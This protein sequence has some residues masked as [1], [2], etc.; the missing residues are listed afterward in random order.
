MAKGKA[1]RELFSVVEVKETM[2][3]RERRPICGRLRMIDRPLSLHAGGVYRADDK[4]KAKYEANRRDLA[5]KA[6]RLMSLVER[7]K[8]KN[9]PAQDRTWLGGAEKAV[10]FEIVKLDGRIKVREKRWSHGL[11]CDTERQL[12]VLEGAVWRASADDKIFNEAGRREVAR[13]G[14]NLLPPAEIA[15]IRKKLG[16]SQR[17]LSEILTGSTSA[18]Q[19]YE[20]GSAVPCRAVS[21]VLEML[22]KH[23]EW[24][25]KR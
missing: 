16:L 2:T 23:P 24:L 5:R 10:A 20:A 25:A 1:R 17:R 22:D 19:K 21:M 15:R 4:D 18:F 3:V 13:E 14:R 7:T 11:L 6:R 8:R 12:S 9:H